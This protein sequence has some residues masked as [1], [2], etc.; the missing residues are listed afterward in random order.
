M[1]P[2]GDFLVLKLFS[3]Q[4]RLASLC[5][6]MLLGILAS[7]VSAQSAAF[8]QALAEAVVDHREVAAF[9]RTRSYAPIW[10]TSA[11]RDRRISLLNAFATATAHGLPGDKFNRDTW[12]N[13]I[14]AASTQ[15]QLGRLEGELSIIFSEYARAIQTG[16]LVPGSVDSQIAR[17]VPYRDITKTLQALVQSS[18]TAFMRSLAPQSPE[19]ARLMKEKLRL[20]RLLGTGGWGAKV[21]ASSLKPGQSGNSVAQ[22]R[23]RLIRMGYLRRTNTVTYDQR[24]TAAVQQFQAAHGLDADG[25]AG[26]GT[27]TEI[28]VQAENRLTQVIVAME[29]ERWINREL[30]KRHV[31]VNLTDF[32]A[33]IVDDGSITFQTR[34]VIG[35]NR[36]DRRSPEFS[37]TMEHMVINP[38]WFVPRSI[39]T[40]E[41][42]PMLQRNPNAVSHLILTDSRGRVVN[43]STT[44]FTQFSR[45]TF[46][47]AIRQPPSRRN[48]LGLVKFMFPNRHNIYLHD[49]PA[50]NLFSRET[51]AF[52]HGC[53]RLNDPFDFAYALL[54]V[55]EDNPKTFFH[56]ILDS[57]RETKVE[58]DQPIPVHI[59]YRTAFTTPKGQLQFRRDIYGRDAKIWQALRNA[60]VVLRALQS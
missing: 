14:G 4:M 47:F 50:K 5:L 15:A 32:H 43:R 9:Y 20:E 57:G 60:G 2:K 30:G 23:N 28:N 24:I 41:Y 58:L 39:A 42:L 34:S 51:R 12:R 10:V 49:T 38:S 44:D 59:V 19:Y 13:Q 27:I 29:R 11:D 3:H 56:R 25:V 33:R 8:K 18:P 26:K 16:V 46:P 48:A 17:Q 40:K 37:D 6:V 52:S 7:P 21:Q 55:Q 45:S 53:I 54:A 35:A 22:L 31:W 36:S 1:L